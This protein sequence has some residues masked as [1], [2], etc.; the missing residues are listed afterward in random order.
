M[1]RE[2]ILAYTEGAPIHNDN[3]PLLE[4]LVPKGLLKRHEYGRENSI[5]MKSLHA[6][7]T[8]QP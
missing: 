4:F 1:D 2:G 5:Q 3:F 7:R 8:F 6:N